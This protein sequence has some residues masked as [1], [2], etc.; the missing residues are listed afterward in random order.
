MQCSVLLKILLSLNVTKVMR[1][2]CHTEAMQCS[3][4]LKILL[5]LNVTKVIRI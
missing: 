1:L 4:L 2:S 5:S 3:V